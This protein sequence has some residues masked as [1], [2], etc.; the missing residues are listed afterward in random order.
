MSTTSDQDSIGGAMQREDAVEALL[1]RATPRPA[2]PSEDEQMIRQ[3]VFTEWQDV[4]GRRRTRSRLARFAIAASVLVAVGTSFM[5]L[6]TDAV[7]PMQVASISKSHGSI[8]V[9][10]EHST[11]Q[12]LPSVSVV[13]AGQTIKTDHDSGIGLNWGNGGSLRIAADTVVE[14]VA[15]DAVYLHS[16]RIYFDSTPSE[17]SIGI[18][19]ASGPETLHIQTDQGTVTHVGTQYMTY[20]AR[21]ELIVS[22]REGEVLIDGKYRDETALAGQQLSVSG[23]ARASV[24]NIDRYGAAWEWIEETSPLV[25]TDGRSVRD[26]LAWV[27][28]ET[29]LEVEYPDAATEQAAKDTVL[30]GSVNLRPSEALDFWL[31]GQDLSWYIDGGAIKVSAIDDSIGR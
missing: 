5:L 26:F 28:R 2:P 19:G 6:Q 15:S 27:G 1:Q 30:K 17:L 9:L 4:T 14:F 29:G 24:L 25:D 11:M 3:A 20:A 7:A 12:R 23:S 31:E 18:A 21:G 8:Y 22:V 16:G 13:M 10:G